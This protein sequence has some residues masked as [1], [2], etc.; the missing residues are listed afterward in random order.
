MASLLKVWARLSC[1]QQGLGLRFSGSRPPSR[2]RLAEPQPR[3]VV[4]I[5]EAE[6]R[7]PQLSGSELLSL[8][9]PAFSSDSIPASSNLFSDLV[10]K[11]RGSLSSASMDEVLQILAMTVYS[12]NQPLDSF[13]PAVVQEFSQ[14]VEKA[15]DQHLAQGLMLLSRRPIKWFHRDLVALF[16]HEL[17]HRT[18][19]KVM[20]AENLA[21]CAEGLYQCGH[22]VSQPYFFK[23]LLAADTWDAP[24][25]AMFMYVAYCNSMSRNQVAK[26]AEKFLKVVNTAD[27][28]PHSVLCVAQAFLYCKRLSP[29]A[30][31]EFFSD[32]GTCIQLM[33]L[34][35][36]DTE[37]LSAL[38]QF[39]IEYKC[40]EQETV[41][42]VLQLCEITEY[43]PLANLAKFVY[44]L[45][46]LR[47]A[48]EVRH[49]PYLLNNRRK[50]EMHEVAGQLKDV[51]M[52]FTG[53]AHIGLNVP[54][55]SEVACQY[56]SSNADL[57]TKH[58]DFE[59]MHLLV[60]LSELQ[61]LSDDVLGKFFQ[62]LP[63][64][65]MDFQTMT[66]FC[67]ACAGQQ[68][69]I[70]D[71]FWNGMV[72][73]CEV[74]VVKMLSDSV[75]HSLYWLNVLAGHQHL[76]QLSKESFAEVQKRCKAKLG[77]WRPLDKEIQ[78]EIESMIGS[79]IVR[80]DV[81]VEN[82]I[83]APFAVLVD[84]KGAPKNWSTVST[85][86][87]LKAGVLEERQL[88]PVVLRLMSS[89]EYIISEYDGDLEDKIFDEAEQAEDSEDKDMG[90]DDAEAHSEEG[91]FPLPPEPVFAPRRQVEV[92]LLCFEAVKWIPVA[93]PIGEWLR[94]EDRNGLLRAVLHDRTAC[95]LED[96]RRREIELVG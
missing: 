8:M 39:G 69:L 19:I 21:L 40:L 13:L 34:K 18:S 32:I 78:K 66:L 75:C 49:A 43:W 46:H 24:E 36:L 79:G 68:G 87:P 95:T 38:L 52:L 92:E 60:S 64:S 94:S 81:A 25:Y 28:S 41:V 14:R 29:Y 16:D 90:T 50:L 44:T 85:A 88:Y 71:R 84:S 47:Q 65:G 63:V 83:V 91:H 31:P 67:V 5:T 26:L 3:E 45:S 53:L 20:K 57:V 96:R 62:I 11:W 1:A 17:Y 33:P 37:R 89:D 80:R 10:E 93:I 9:Y 86:T 82:G 15:D 59:A 42:K 12:V 27:L 74:D 2:L 77:T 30:P 23:F 73:H 48:D 61:V 51:L 72:D 76:R 70:P 54:K 55:W 56:L 6:R 7:A 4:N 58:G 35:S 22:V